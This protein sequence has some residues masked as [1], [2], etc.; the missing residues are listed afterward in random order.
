MA[1][2]GSAAWVVTIVVIIGFIVGA[3]VFSVVDPV[4][5]ALFDSAIWSSDTA[6]GQNLLSWLERSWA[7][8]PAAVLLG[9]LTTVWVETR[10]PV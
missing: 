1:T 4:A 10:Q 5:Q 6:D 8:A 3:L 2:R 7:F 9:L